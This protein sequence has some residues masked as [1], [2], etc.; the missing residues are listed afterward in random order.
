MGQRKSA[1]H[2][3]QPGRD[4]EAR[5]SLFII[6][7]PTGIG[8]RDQ[9]ADRHWFALLVEAAQRIEPQGRVIH[10]VASNGPERGVGRFIRDYKEQC[11]SACRAVLG[12]T[13]DRAV[14][15][16]DERAPKEGGGVSDE[17]ARLA[18]AG[19]GITGHGE[20][21]FNLPPDQRTGREIDD[22]GEAPTDLAAI[23]GI[24]CG[25]CDSFPARAT[26]WGASILHIIPG[27]G[28][29]RSARGG[30]F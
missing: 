17:A 12:A 19:V 25:H 2:I 26:R 22:D 1:G 3:Q 18:G 30:Q 10:V 21:Q 29:A 28:R 16:M 27:T 9:R 4:S 14:Q 15:F 24:D 13:C 5:V 6:P 7:I 11:D 8:E 23:G 20:Q